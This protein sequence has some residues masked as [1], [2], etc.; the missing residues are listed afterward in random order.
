MSA[1]MKSAI[2]ARNAI[3]V[4]SHKE[5][6]RRSIDQRL[7]HRFKNALGRGL[8]LLRTPIASFRWARAKR[9]LRAKR[10]CE[11]PVGIPMI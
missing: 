2:E 3:Y 8:L 6:C 5:I 7:W 10:G 4:L 9:K 1:R 11:P